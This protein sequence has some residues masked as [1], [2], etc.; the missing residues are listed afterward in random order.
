MERKIRAGSGHW[1][2]RVPAGR[3]P[4]SAGSLRGGGQALRLAEAAAE[5][6]AFVLFAPPDLARNWRD[7]AR[8]VV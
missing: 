3:N 5:R 1:R 4:I 6:V 2:G 8:Q 7:A